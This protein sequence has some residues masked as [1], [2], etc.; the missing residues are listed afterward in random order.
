MVVPPENWIL[1]AGK[2]RFGQ[3]RI[4]SLREFYH[5]DLKKSTKAIIKI[6]NI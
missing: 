1:P 2:L 6:R 5:A 3:L 4:F